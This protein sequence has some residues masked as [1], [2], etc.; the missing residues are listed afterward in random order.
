MDKLFVY[1]PGPTNVR[2]NVRL[3]RSMETTNPDLDGEFF[4]YYK[5]TCNKVASIL[6]TKNDTFI[7][8]GEG[9]LGLEAACAS[10]TE[11]NDKVLV[12]DNG[13][14]GEG[15]K[16]FIKIYGGE[17]ILYSSNRKNEIDIEDLKIFLEKNHDFKY[18]TIVHCDTPSGVLNDIKNICPLL[19]KYG[20]VTVV[21]SVAAMVGEP[22][23]ID[24]W[25]IDII[26]GGSQKAFSAPPGLTIVAISEDAYK[27][28]GNRKTQITSF[29]GNLTIWK[30]Y[31]TQKTFPYTMPISD[32]IGFRT[33]V[34]NILEE[35]LENIQLRHK[36]IAEAVRKSL[37]SY[38]FK[39]YLE[40]GY[41][42]TVT[43]VEP[44]EGYEVS[45][46]INHMREKYNL[47][48]AGSFD[49]LSNKVIRIGHMGE[50][51]NL[52]FVIYVLNVLDLAMRDLGYENKVSLV[53]EFNK[54][55]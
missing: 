18:A 38:G 26:L 49:Y 47:L 2:E 23:E 13:V 41:A 3:A 7:L 43:V 14:F 35:G 25:G 53:D 37:V 52:N 30:D 19:K 21:D 10:L 29:Y 28:M 12:I 45:K 20:I 44:P 11:K 5:D 16:D 51:A 24:N 36:K 46:I 32:I 1:T 33:A 34:D 22:L 50:N 31:Y 40:S 48:I 15:F 54:N 55:I 9:I 17:P 6:G 42:S 8:G 27:I 4:D 39:L